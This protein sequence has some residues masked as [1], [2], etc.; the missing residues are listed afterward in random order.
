MSVAAL[1]KK[2][3]ECVD[4]FDFEN[5]RKFCAKAVQQSPMDVAALELL[6]GILLE[7]GEPHKAMEVRH[8]FLFLSLSL[9]F[10]LLF[11]SLLFFLSLPFSFLMRLI[12]IS[13]FTEIP[14]VHCDCSQ[15]WLHQ[16]PE[17]GAA[18]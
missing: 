18:S 2:A 1:M 12:E 9:F 10:S 8:R 3:Q 4:E 5:A 17:H 14:E 6:G 11:F 13:R 7:L 15:H 16:V